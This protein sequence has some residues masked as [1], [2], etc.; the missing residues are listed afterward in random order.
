MRWLW[1]A[2]DRAAWLCQ[3]AVARWLNLKTKQI[4]PV[5]KQLEF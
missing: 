4:A 3:Q 5:N 1:Q 2:F